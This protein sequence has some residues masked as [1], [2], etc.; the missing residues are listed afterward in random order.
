MKLYTYLFI[1]ILNLSQ[2]CIFNKKT[3]TNERKTYALKLDSINMFDSVRNRIVPVALYLPSSNQKIDHQKVVILSHGYNV[4]RGGSN[5]EYSYLATF[6]ATQGY[7]VASIQHELPTDDTIPLQGVPQIVRRP[8][9]ERGAKNILFVLNELK[10]IY[11]ELDYQHLVLIGHSNGGDMSMLFGQQYPGLVDKI[12]SLDSRRMA[13]PR[14]SH[15]KIYSLRS[16]DQLADEGVL[17]TIDEQKKYGTQIIKLKHT[18]HNDMDDSGT[19]N[20]KKEINKYIL[21]FLNDQS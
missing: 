14:S 6:L 21:K 17:P 9:W 19:D 11:P 8:F 10:S 1:F 7:F 20:Q 18:I 2:G 12:I 5:K 13:F 16:C 4:N 3:T 15:P